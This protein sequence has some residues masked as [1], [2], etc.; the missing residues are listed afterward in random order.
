MTPIVELVRLETGK[1]GTFGALLIC[2]KVFCFTLEPPDRLN[3]KRVSSIPP[4][5]YICWRHQSPRFGETFQILEVPDRSEILFHS[6]NVVTN[7]EGCILLG[8]TIGKLKGDRAVLNSGDTFKAFMKAVEGF[9]AF[10]L[11]IREVY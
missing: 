2:K 11:T 8:S 1:Q 5:Q 3:K 4:S 7:T 6:G 10:H 9:Q